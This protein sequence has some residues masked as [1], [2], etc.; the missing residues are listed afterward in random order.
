MRLGYSLYYSPSF[1][2]LS[3]DPSHTLTHS[4]DP[5]KVLAAA[6]PSVEPPPARGEGAAAR[7][8]G[9]VAAAASRAALAK[10][11]AALAKV[12]VAAGGT[13]PPTSVSGSSSPT[14]PATPFSVFVSGS[15]PDLTANRRSVELDSSPRG[16]EEEA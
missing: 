16:G 15:L 3:I 12:L 9:A 4:P 11:L 5:V 2:F 8:E 1:F 14:L 7:G 10:V 6:R 13:L